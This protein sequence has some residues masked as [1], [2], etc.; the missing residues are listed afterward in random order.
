MHEPDKFE[1]LI[2]FEFSLPLIC[3][4]TTTGSK[5]KKFYKITCMADSSS[6]SCLPLHLWDE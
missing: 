1:S 5:L 3:K 2:G 6:G 4:S